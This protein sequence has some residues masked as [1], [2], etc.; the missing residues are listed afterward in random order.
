MTSMSNSWPEG[1]RGRRYVKDTSPASKELRCA[2]QIHTHSP[3]IIN[4][5]MNSEDKKSYKTSGEGVVP[6]EWGVW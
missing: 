1:R 2:M 5:K 3:V 6:M 4:T